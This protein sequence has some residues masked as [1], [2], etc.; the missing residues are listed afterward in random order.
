MTDTLA[1]KGAMPRERAAVSA[2]FLANGYVVGNWAPRIPTFKADL[3]I[4]EAVLGL[5]ILAFGIGSL[6]T[7]PL[8]G[9][10]VAREGSRRMSLLTG[11]RAG[12]G[13][14]AADADA[15]TLDG[16]GGA[17]RARRADRR[18]GRGDER[19]RRGGGA[20][21]RRAIM[22]SCHGWWSLGGL[23]GAASGGVLIGR[24]GVLGA[25]GGGDLV[26]RSASSSRRRPR[27]WPTAGG[28]AAG[29]KAGGR[30]RGLLRLLVGLD[31]ALLDDPGGRG[32]RLERALPRA[33]ARRLGRDRRPRLRG[34]LGDDGGHALQRRPD[35]R[36]AGGRC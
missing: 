18:H 9:A 17:G 16:G 13:A 31:G 25:C 6:V 32:A 21:M 33:G 10:V 34:L 4:D 27:C 29:G 22:S 24:L 12:A 1:L 5:M 30:C 11:A 28:K 35:P 23:I 14:A 36:P 8:V 15:G 26:W 2:L 7:M 20:R 3:G 19:Q